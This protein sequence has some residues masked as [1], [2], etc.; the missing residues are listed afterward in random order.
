MQRIIIL[1]SLIS[2]MLFAGVYDYNYNINEK[3]SLKSTPLDEKLMYGNFDKI[4]RFDPLIFNSNINN[5]DKSS[6]DKIKKIIK[7]IKSYNNEN[8]IVTLIGYSQQTESHNEKVLRE[9]SFKNRYIDK[10]TQTQKELH[11]KIDS[12]LN[13]LRKYFM[14]HGIKKDIVV[15]EIRDDKEENF[16]ECTELGQKLNNRVMVTIYKLSKENKLR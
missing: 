2:S 13:L 5:F 12:Y 11:E 15:C 1:L 10:N 8:I 6:K 16:T 14:D 4:I 9:I 3:I 7:I